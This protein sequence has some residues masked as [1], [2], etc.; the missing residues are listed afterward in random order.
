MADDERLHRP[1]PERTAPRRHAATYLRDPPASDMPSAGDET[2]DD[3]PVARGVR[4]GYQVL[5]EQL[6]EGQRLAQRLGKATGKAGAA[7]S[8]EIGMLVE[9]LRQ[10]YQDI[11]TLVRSP[12][13]RTGIAGTMRSTDDGE[14]ARASDGAA[15]AV[16]VEIASP[17]RTRVTL[18]LHTRDACAAPR[19]HALHATDPAAPPLTTVGFEHDP[20][21]TVPRLSIDVPHD[22]APGTYTGVVVDGTSNEP[23]GT[24]SVR[25][26][27]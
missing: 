11:G 5:E 25:L 26:L 24:L 3:D 21:S 4:V 22:Q 20:A 16:A 14:R 10:V 17:R 8:G 2:G 6:R 12:L 15:T 27:P 19:V 23:I 13:V 7:A 18:A 1:E 9:R